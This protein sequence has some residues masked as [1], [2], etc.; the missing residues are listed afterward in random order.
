M[1]PVKKMEIFLERSRLS[2][3]DLSRRHCELED[4]ADVQNP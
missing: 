4:A 1:H 3:G 2:T